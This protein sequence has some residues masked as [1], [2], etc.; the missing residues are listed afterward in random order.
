MMKWLRLSSPGRASQGNEL[1]CV[2]MFVVKEQCPAMFYDVHV[3]SASPLLS[4]IIWTRLSYVSCI[5]HDL[6]GYLSYYLGRSLPVSQAHS[7]WIGI[8]IESIPP[9]VA[10]QGNAI[11]LRHLYGE[12]AGG[13]ARDQ[14]GSFQSRSLLQ[15]L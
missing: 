8:H 3:I 14:Y 2:S 9:R 10:N 11:S 13:G 15:H 1:C 4:L 5:V 12:R 6:G 7:L